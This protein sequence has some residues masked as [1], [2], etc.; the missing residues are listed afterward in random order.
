[1][2]TLPIFTRDQIASRIIAGETLLIYRDLLINIPPSWLDAHPGG[3]LAILHFVGRDATDVIESFHSEDTVKN[4]RRY[5]VGRIEPGEDGWQ[6]LQP[7]IMSGWVR[8]PGQDGKPKWFREA[9]ILTSTEDASLPHSSKFLL[10]DKDNALAQPAALAPSL[11][12]LEPPSTDLSSKVQARHSEAYKALHKRLIDAGYYNT[13]YLTGYGSEFGRYFLLGGLSAVAYSHNWLM[14]SA[15]FLG[16][17]W[18]QLAFAAHDFG[19][20]AV[21]HHWTIDR[22]LGII[23]TNFIGGLSIGWWVDVSVPCCGRCQRLTLCLDF[24]ATTF[25]IVRFPLGISHPTKFD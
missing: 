21:S 19:H 3:S 6:T 16:F 12:T 17:L 18:H 14:T 25:I 7:P 20:V 11:D 9:G 8:K 15:L 2:L 22:I 1:M 23:L 24:R 10:V 13:P 4:V 5:A